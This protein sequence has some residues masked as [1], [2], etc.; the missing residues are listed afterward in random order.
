MSKQNR[1]YLNINVDVGNNLIVEKESVFKNK[2]KDIGESEYMDD[3]E[4]FQSSDKFMIY[5]KLPKFTRDQISVRLNSKNIL[6]IEAKREELCRYGK[7]IFEVIR[8]YPIQ[9]QYDSDSIECEWKRDST[10]TISLHKYCDIPN[11]Q[12][13]QDEAEIRHSC[14]KICVS[15]N[16]GDF[17]KE[18]IIIKI[19]NGNLIVKGKCFRRETDSAC[20]NISVKRKFKRVY[21]VG[22]DIDVD[23][24]KSKIINQ[25]LYIELPKIR[26]SNKSYIID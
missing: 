15:L 7:N 6:S 11:V 12:K 23:E 26:K 10:L 20:K 22:H 2:S 24:I 13:T 25:R 14:D 4:I 9:A 21:L 17:R 16:I 3:G 19:K 18:E 1:K 8:N 5:L